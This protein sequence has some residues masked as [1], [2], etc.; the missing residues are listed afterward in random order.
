MRIELEL[1]LQGPVLII[2]VWETPHVTASGT[3][4]KRRVDAGEKP[5]HL[6]RHL[7]LTPTSSGLVH[8]LHI[9]E[10]HDGYHDGYRPAGRYDQVGR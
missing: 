4:R 3:A 9:L 8:S 1:E 10:G 7:R 5:S 6:C 2:T